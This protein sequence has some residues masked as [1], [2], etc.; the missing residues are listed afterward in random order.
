MEQIKTSSY[1][2]KIATDYIPAHTS[3][4]SDVGTVS[5]SF[6]PF[7]NTGAWGTSYSW[8]A[9]DNRCTGTSVAGVAEWYYD[10]LKMPKNIFSIKFK[11]CSYNGLGTWVDNAKISIYAE[12]VDDSMQ[13]L[14]DNWDVH[15]AQLADG[16]FVFNN[17]VTTQNKQIKK[18]TVRANFP[19]S[20]ACIREFQIIAR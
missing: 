16:Y 20:G 17:N 11:T 14:I 5:L 4:N 10:F 12:Y 15:S 2:N 8:V 13:T 7:T 9:M 18:L 6:T 19:N 1:L 3:N